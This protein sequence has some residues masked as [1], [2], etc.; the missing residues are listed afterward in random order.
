MF[1]DQMDV[2]IETISLTSLYYG[3]SINGTI[4]MKLPSCLAVQLGHMHVDFTKASI[5][6]GLDLVNAS[7]NY[8][9][10]PPPVIAATIWL[11]TRLLSFFSYLSS[12]PLLFLSTIRMRA[13]QPHF[14]SIALVFSFLMHSTNHPTLLPQKPKTLIVPVHD[15]SMV[16]PYI[17]VGTHWLTPCLSKQ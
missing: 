16:S 2:Q 11:K 10:F 14:P 12:R 7:I 13:H 15:G 17:Q 6:H 9:W 3:I 4:Q 8:L 1:K 5:K